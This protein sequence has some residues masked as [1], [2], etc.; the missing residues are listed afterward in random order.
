MDKLENFSL[1]QSTPS[2]RVPTSLSRSSSKKVNLWVLEMRHFAKLQVKCRD[3]LDTD[4]GQGSYSQSHD[5]GLLGEGQ[6]QSSSFLFLKKMF[7]LF[8]NYS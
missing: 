1:L 2:G 4:V 5:D 8:S 3:L 6:Y 7:L